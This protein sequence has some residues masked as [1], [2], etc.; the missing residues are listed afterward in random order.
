V[1]AGSRLPDVEGLVV[2]ITLPDE[3]ARNRGVM[4]T[5]AIQGTPVA[6]QVTTATQLEVARGK[7]VSRAA[8]ADIEKGERVSVW[9]QSSPVGS[10]PVAPARKIILFRAG[11]PQLPHP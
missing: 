7:V 6:V 11:S 9:Y 4:E 5:L 1:N 10:P 2:E 3:A 8:A